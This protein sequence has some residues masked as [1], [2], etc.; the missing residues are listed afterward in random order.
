MSHGSM[1]PASR[2][3]WLK[4]QKNQMKKFKVVPALK[5]KKTV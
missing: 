4:D 3:G 5:K 2:R 1:G